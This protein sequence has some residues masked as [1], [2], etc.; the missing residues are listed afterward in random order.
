MDKDVI[1]IHNELTTQPTNTKA[2]LS[3]VT[4]WMDLQDIM[5]SE[6]V[7]VRQILCDSTCMWNLKQTQ[8]NKQ[9]KAKK[10]SQREQIAGS[11]EK[12]HCGEGKIRE[13]GHL[14]SDGW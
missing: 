14:Y 9:N 10:K 12:G 3:F 5:L 7:R 2:I 11:R 4:I 6:K 13:S 1:Y 8:T